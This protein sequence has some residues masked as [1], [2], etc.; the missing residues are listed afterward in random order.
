MAHRTLFFVFCSFCSLL[1]GCKGYEVTINQ[2]PVYTPPTVASLE[3]IADDNLAHCINQ[4]LADQD[5]SRA[6]QLKRLI[7]TKAGIEDLTG[8][9][10]LEGLE[11]LDLS[12][13]ALE[14]ITPLLM[15]KQ[16]TLVRLKDNPELSCSDLEQLVQLRGKD[17]E[18]EKPAHCS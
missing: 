12:H 1:F 14:R 9:E 18:L 2:Q 17:M 7:C 15:L 5:I 13:N 8:I 16:L 3:G 11:Q 10:Q 4:T 6:A